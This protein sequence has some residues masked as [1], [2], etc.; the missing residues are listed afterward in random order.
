MTIEMSKKI[1]L[2]NLQDTVDEIN[3]QKNIHPS[4]CMFRINPIIEHGKSM[5]ARDEMMRLNIINPNRVDGKT[6]TINE[7]VSMLAFYEPF[8]PIWIDV[9]LNQY[10]DE[11]AEF[12]LDCSLRLRKPSLLRNKE[13]GHPPFRAVM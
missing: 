1:F 5:Q 2:H 9:K 11:E 10:I 13:S 3:L 8:V 7:V 4:K 6:F 12:Q